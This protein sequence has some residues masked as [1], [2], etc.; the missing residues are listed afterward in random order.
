[1]EDKASF[2]GSNMVPSVTKL[3]QNEQQNIKRNPDC[4]TIVDNGELNYLNVDI[5]FSIIYNSLDNLSASL[6]K[7]NVDT[8]QPR[9]QI[10]LSTFQV[11]NSRI[12]RLNL[13]V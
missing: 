8:A 11:K 3:T 9:D 6:H 12:N 10:V 13:D 2:G 7:F 4:K 1:M 5:H